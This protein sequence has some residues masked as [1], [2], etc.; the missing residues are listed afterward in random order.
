MYVLSKHTCTDYCH[1]QHKL[2][3]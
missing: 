3:N 2:H 1:K